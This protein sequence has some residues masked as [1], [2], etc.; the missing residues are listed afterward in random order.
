M[1]PAPPMIGP[2]E[3]EVELLVDELP[4]EDV[5]PVDPAPPGVFPELSDGMPVEPDPLVGGV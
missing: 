5:L 4:L 1:M 3:P 2:L